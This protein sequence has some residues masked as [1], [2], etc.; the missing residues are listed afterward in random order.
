[1][2]GRDLGKNPTKKYGVC[3]KHY[4]NVVCPDTPPNFWNPKI[5]DT[6]EDE[7]IATPFD[8]RFAKD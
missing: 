6:P 5:I 2:L 4:R 7:R 8:S 1:M 3:S